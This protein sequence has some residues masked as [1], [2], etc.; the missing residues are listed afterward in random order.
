MA[1]FQ[2]DAEN[3]PVAIPHHR[4]YQSM[5]T[6]K[7]FLIR[8]ENLLSLQVKAR[9]PVNALCTSFIAMPVRLSMKSRC[10]LKERG[11]RFSST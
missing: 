9:Y 5:I 11:N 10:S 2:T 3:K 6:H 7:I 4:I 8:F 1:V